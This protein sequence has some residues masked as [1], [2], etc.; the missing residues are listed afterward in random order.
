[1]TTPNVVRVEFQNELMRRRQ[2]EIK[3]N[4]H[5]SVEL[6]DQNQYDRN[7]YIYFTNAKTFEQFTKM[8]KIRPQK[9]NIHILKDEVDEDWSKYLEKYYLNIRRV[10]PLLKK[11]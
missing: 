4:N 5:P 8:A 7:R 2:I 9:K 3:I 1:M 11:E 6:D 10:K